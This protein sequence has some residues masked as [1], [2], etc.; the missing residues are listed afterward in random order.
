MLISFPYW[1]PRVLQDPKVRLDI[2]KS[3]A[4]RIA[5]VTG[6]SS[7]IGLE[8]SK[9]LA[10]RGAE[11]LVTSRSLDRARAAWGDFG[12]ALDLSDFES[13]RQFAA[14]V[15]THLHGRR[16]DIL[17]LNAGITYGP[18]YPGPYATPKGHDM[19]VASNHLGHFLLVQELWPVLEASKT[20]LVVV[21]SIA[22]W[23]VKSIGD[24]IAAPLSVSYGEQLSV[25]T[26]LQTYGTSKLM[27]VLWAYKLQRDLASMGASVVVCTPGLV[28]TSLGVPERGEGK[29]QSHLVRF[30]MSA[31]AG[32]EVLASAVAV[33]E[34]QLQGKLL[35]PYWIWESLALLLPLPLRSLQ[36]LIHEILMQKMTWGLRRHSSSP[37]SY[38]VT[39]QEELWAWSVN[40]TTT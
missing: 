13:V 39:L 25:E 32:G 34:S 26:V 28:S 9:L 3:L 35:M 29:S 31:R 1:G 4:S 30:R 24:P 7:G 36:V 8:A 10:A 17:I 18:D 19:L 5:V 20:R 22:H 16:L 11:V 15:T 40:A 33:E 12:F 14:N 23:L 2:D 38:N 21:S 27:N 6:G 37:E